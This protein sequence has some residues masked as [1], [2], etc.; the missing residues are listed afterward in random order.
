MAYW[1]TG[2]GI[3]IF[4]LSF[5]DVWLSY[6]SAGDRYSRGAKTS[7]M[8]GS[9]FALAL[10]QIMAGLMMALLG[11]FVLLERVSIPEETLRLILYIGVGTFAGTFVIGLI[12]RGISSPR[13]RR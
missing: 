2:I 11:G 8:S 1:L 13:K 6:V 5:R 3:V 4:F 12:I 9:A 7:M 10:I